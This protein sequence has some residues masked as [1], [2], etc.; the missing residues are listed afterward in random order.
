MFSRKMEPEEKLRSCEAQKGMR[1]LDMCLRVSTAAVKHH[2]Q[3]TRGEGVCLPY[4]SISL[5]S[6]KK[7]S[8]G[9]QTGQESGDRA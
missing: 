3:K 5:S 2:D 9:T 4:T 6:S 7:V 1:E 8:R